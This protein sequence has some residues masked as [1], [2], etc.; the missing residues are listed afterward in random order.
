VEKGSTL[1]RHS[2]PSIEGSLSRPGSHEEQ[3]IFLVRY[4]YTL[5]E[6]NVYGV[7]S[8]AHQAFTRYEDEQIHSP[9]VI[10]SHGMLVSLQR[11][12]GPKLNTLPASS[13]RI[14]TPSANTLS[15]AY[16]LWTAFSKSFRFISGPYSIPMH[17]QPGANMSLSPNR[18]NQKSSRYLIHRPLRLPNTVLVCHAL[19]RCWPRASRM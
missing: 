3:T 16:L 8:G 17:I 10:R 4:E 1:L 2:T 14:R 11:V 6:G 15:Q 18:L 7:A 19:P 13:T 12:E 5:E 9:G